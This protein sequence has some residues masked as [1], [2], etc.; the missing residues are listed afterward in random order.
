MEIRDYISSVLACVFLAFTFECCTPP[1]PES[2]SIGCENAKLFQRYPPPD[3]SFSPARFSKFDM[4]EIQANGKPSNHSM[5]IAIGRTEEWERCG[6]SSISKDSSVL[7]I[8]P[9]GKNP[10]NPPMNWIGIVQYYSDDSMKDLRSELNFKIVEIK[11]NQ[12]GWDTLSAIWQLIN[13]ENGVYDTIASVPFPF[14]VPEGCKI[15]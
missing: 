7:R 5:G 1:D 4:L 10:S 11:E 13:Y 6:F 2:N 9:N 3:Y 14:E 12:F 8:T 15:P